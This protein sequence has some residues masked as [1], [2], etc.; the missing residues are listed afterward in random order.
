[1]NF[2]PLFLVLPEKKAEDIQQ[3]NRKPH[4]KNINI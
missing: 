2:Y 4:V 3:K 1:M